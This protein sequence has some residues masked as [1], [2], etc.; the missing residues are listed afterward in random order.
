M[1][2]PHKGNR[3]SIPLSTVNNYFHVIDKPEA[4]FFFLKRPS[5]KTATM[6]V[7]NPEAMSKAGVST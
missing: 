4:S 3:M 1:L 2:P 7:R 5:P 6:T